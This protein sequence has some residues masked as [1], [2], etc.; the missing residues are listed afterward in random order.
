[1]K[2][3]TK[4]WIE[5]L[6][7]NNK[8]Q[9]I[10]GKFNITTPLISDGDEYSLMEKE[11]FERMPFC[12]LSNDYHI[13]FSQRATDF[14]NALFK[15]YV[16]DNTLVIYSSC[17]HENVDKAVSKCKN[18]LEIFMDDIF[19]LSFDNYINKI[20]EFKKIFV[21]IIGTQITTGMITPQSFFVK[22]KAIL[23]KN[24]IDNI[25]VIDD[26]HG[27]FLTPRDYTL[28][29]YII[30]TAH[31]LIRNFDM[32]LLVS[33][34]EDFGIKALNWG[35]E[36][37]EMLDIILK[38]KEKMRLFSQVM[39]NEFYEYVA[40]GKFI[41][42]SLTTPHIFSPR[43]TDHMFTQKMY[44]ILDKNE[45]R[46]EGL[47]TDN[48][49]IRFRAQHYIKNPEYLTNAIKLMYN[50]LNNTETPQV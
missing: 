8:E 40:N 26:V 23:N 30:Y 21:Y 31:S 1:M 33:K 4:W 13:T 45:V 46:L 28:F 5:Y 42:N 39:T 9:E 49:H 15:K 32:G 11:Y 38:R 37:L 6:P 25:F 44:D 7:L 29:D 50:I 36:Y 10:I 2:D 14:I 18:T 47:H 24:N 17:E 12:N 19:T 35:N 34:K 16:D 41:L 20:K 48:I 3:L 22:L 27:M 43:I